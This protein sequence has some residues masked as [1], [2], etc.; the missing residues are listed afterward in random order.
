M[1]DARQ[2]IRLDSIHV[3]DDRIRPVDEAAAQALAAL[4]RDQGQLSPIAVYSSHAGQKAFTLIYGARRFRAMEIL[5]LDV[6]EAVLRTKAE[7][8]ML[9]ITDN[10][11]PGN[12]KPLEVC[13]YCKSFEAFWIDKHGPIQ[14]G[15][16]RKSNGHRGRLISQDTEK[17][18][19]YNSLKELSGIPERTARRY[20]KIGSMHPTLRNA[21]RNTPALSDFGLLTKFSKLEADEQPRAAA[22]LVEHADL[23]AAL[24]LV[25]PDKGRKDETQR[26]EDI[27]LTTWSLLNA[28]QR[29]AFLE[30][31]GAMMKP[32]PSGFDLSTSLQTV[33]ARNNPSPLRDWS[34]EPR[35]LVDVQSAE[36]LGYDA[37]AKPKT[38]PTPRLSAKDDNLLN[39]LSCELWH[40]MQ[41]SGGKWNAQLIRLCAKLDT[42]YQAKMAAKLWRKA[43]MDA[44]IAHATI[45]LAEQK[46]SRKGAK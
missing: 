43:N 32:L 27:M 28:A 41:V 9:E 17:L 11:Q 5:G 35:E 31:V 46:L 30:S 33:P 23:T 20:L 16:D 6:I 40:K 42:E 13:E 19:F 4:I 44:S 1:K 8:A 10:L 24:K 21:L 14:R 22:A 39:G 3:P 26:R 38:K 37:P 34:A 2:T 12:L 29:Q 45:L 18:S 36:Q 7:A 25:R 15:G